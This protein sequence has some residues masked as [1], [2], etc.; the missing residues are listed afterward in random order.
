MESIKTKTELFRLLLSSVILTSYSYC[1]SCYSPFVDS[2]ISTV[3]NDSISNFNLELTGE[4]PTVIGGQPYRIISRYWQSPSNQ[5]AAQYIYEKFQRYGL[6]TRYQTYSSTGVNVIAKKTGSK[7]PN[8][9]FIICAHYDNITYPQLSDTIYGADDN[10]SGTC[11]VLEAARVL[12]NYNPDYTVI[13]AAWDE[14]ETGLI[15]STNYADTATLHQDSIMC[16]FNLD[17]I[18]YDVSNGNKY[19]ILTD[20]A[21]A[22][23]AVLFSTA[24]HFYQPQLIPSFRFGYGGSDH[25]AFWDKGY[26]AICGIENSPGNPYM[27]SIYDRF[28][29]LNLS[30]FE[31]MVKISIASLVIASDDYLINILHEPLQS[32]YD[33]TARI[34][35]AVITSNHPIAI[36]QNAPRLYWKAGSG[37]YNYTNAFLINLDT[38][39]FLIPG[40][41]LGNTVFYYLSAQDSLG[42]MVGSLPGG[43]RGINPPGTIPP[44]SPFV[45]RVL[46]QANFCS[47]T[48]PKQLLPMKFT[49]DTIHVSQSGN[50][51]DYDLNLTIYHT[52]DSSLYF[53]LVRPG[54]SI[55]PL[56]T[57]NGGYGQNYINTTFDDEALIP[58]TQG[59][60]PF[61]GSFSPEYPLSTYDNL[62]MEGDWILRIFNSS[63]TITGQLASWCLDFDYYVPIGIVNNQIPTKSSLSQ[64]YPNPFNSS[65]R[66]N[67]SLVKKSHVRI[68]VYDILGREVRVLINE[69]VNNGE[70]SLSFNAN[71]FAS[72]MYFYSMYV[73]GNFYECRK[74]VLVK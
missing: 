35:T 58:I 6:E 22:Y 2:I 70:H 62:P 28:N 26:K 11:C 1:Q 46:R 32:C 17:M 31:S 45:Y 30:F 25:T 68:A 60:P 53:W 48:L 13:F 61:T 59:T 8:K 51:Y 39:K 71:N 34:V 47:N 10:G 67:F 14:E 3:S 43:A 27:H 18:G 57:A 63:Q 52:F 21:S 64:N 72:G 15:G 24:G 74:M 42:T 12:R 23:Y 9:Q 41:P 36:Q 29:K 50:I 73:D 56:S 40:Q 4:I 38:F 5:K 33:T 66:I 54:S 7:Y 16:V 37:S 44:P 65:T 55:I 69:L 19:R 49:Y 20:T